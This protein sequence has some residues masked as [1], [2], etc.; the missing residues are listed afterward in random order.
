MH[1]P[2]ASSNCFEFLFLTLIIKLQSLSPTLQNLICEVRGLTFPL[3]QLASHW[4]IIGPI[5]IYYFK[6][7]DPYLFYRKH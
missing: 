4:L 5:F 6:E 1:I 7:V 3:N 2:N